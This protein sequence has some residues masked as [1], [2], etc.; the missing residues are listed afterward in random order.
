[1]FEILKSMFERGKITAEK[2]IAAFEKGWITAE[3]KDE[4][5]K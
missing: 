3:Q 4:I 2:I 1:M 5:L